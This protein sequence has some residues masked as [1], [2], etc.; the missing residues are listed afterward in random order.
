M[1]GL[2]IS[3]AFFAAALIL[4]VA[5]G[6]DNIFVLAQSALFGARAGIAT[7]LGLV[8]GLCFHTLAVALGVAALLAASPAAFTILKLLGAGYLCWLAW[9]AFHAGAGAAA[10]GSGAFPGYTALYRRGIIMNVTNPKVC[11]FFLAFLP[12]FCAPGAGPMFLQIVYFGFLFML[13]TLTVFCPI[14]L[15][16]GKLA[17]WFNSSPQKRILLQRAASAV[18]IVLAIVLLLADAG[19]PA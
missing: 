6:P 16:G 7:T 10:S 4:G 15:L 1:P 12:Q 13:S 9:Q 8:S 3:A 19:T 18:F 14:A 5:P 2:E 11:L 17:A